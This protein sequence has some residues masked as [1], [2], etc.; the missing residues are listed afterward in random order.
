MFFFKTVVVSGMGT[1]QVFLG[2]HPGE[3]FLEPFVNAEGVS[4]FQPRATPWEQMSFKSKWNSERVREFN[5][6]LN[7]FPQPFQGWHGSMAGYPGVA[8]WRAQPRAGIC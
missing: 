8:R 5:E 6:V 4:K 2:P 7:V 1:I 3:S